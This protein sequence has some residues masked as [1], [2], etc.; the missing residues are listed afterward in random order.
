[1]SNPEPKKKK[2]TLLSRL[3]GKKPEGVEKAEDDTDVQK[4]NP[5]GKRINYRN[6]LQ[7]IL[8]DDG[9]GRMKTVEQL[10]E[11]IFTHSI[12]DLKPVEVIA[13]DGAEE[14]FT[15]DSVDHNNG[16]KSIFGWN[17]PD[18]IV[19]MYQAPF[20]GYQACAYLALNWLIERACSTPPK[21]AMT[22]GFI[23]NCEDKQFQLDNAEFYSENFL[24]TF[25][26]KLVRKYEIDKICVKASTQTRI[27]GVSYIIPI[28]KDTV[29]T[30]EPFDIKNVKA[31]D[32]LGFLNVE[33]QWVEP[34]FDTDA[35][36]N[37][38]ARDGYLEPTYFAIS[39]P[40]I[41]KRYHHSWVIRQTRGYVGDILKGMYRWGGVPLPQQIMYRVYAAER[42]ADEIPALAVSKRL[43]VV[44]GDYLDWEADPCSNEKMLNWIA[45]MRDNYGVYAKPRDTTVQQL[46][47]SLTDFPETAMLEYNLVASQAEMPAAKLMKTL[48]N[49][50]NAKNDLDTKDYNSILARINE[51]EF[52][53][54]IVFASQL[55][56]KSDYG[57]DDCVLEPTFGEYDTLTALELAQVNETKSLTDAHYIAA[58]VLDVEEVR[59][60]LRT[61]PKSGYSNLK[62]EIPEVNL[63][64]EGG[65]KNMYNG[66]TEK[67]EKGRMLPTKEKPGGV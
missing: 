6:Q 38:L 53:P 19:A 17:I 8:I 25:K 27:F 41:R 29:E 67:D 46:D 33:P 49:R 59:Q 64:D 36:N 23:L 37:P 39:T 63:E 11:E 20:I 14:K 28:M 47:T 42:V 9:F 5:L 55:V 40:A 7:P 54:V 12:Y 1:M 34:Q 61:D 24:T 44:D 3:F 45:Q 66:R 21:D 60:R 65:E 48:P 2:P 15:G 16:P 57:R 52:T 32:L 58:G 50:Y 4:E 18:K 43:M 13:S 22:P 10:K 26:K 35:A 51:Q 31:G 56:L 30:K 62:E